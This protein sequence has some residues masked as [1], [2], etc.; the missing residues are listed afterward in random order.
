M[1]LIQLH[2]SNSKYTLRIWNFLPHPDTML[3]NS[4]SHTKAV[5]QCVASQ[6]NICQY[7]QRIGH[8]RINTVRIIVCVNNI[9]LDEYFCFKY[10]I[11]N[12]ITNLINPELY[13]LYYRKQGFLY[14]AVFHLF[15]AFQL[16]YTYYTYSETVLFVIVHLHW[17]KKFIQR[18]VCLVL[19]T[20]A[21]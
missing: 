21:I 8:R 11:R 1:S 18:T 17:H 19:F 14:C 16:F 20:S 9:P 13:I 2:H 12:L 10:I 4:F 15:D 3:K 5:S 7:L 6:T